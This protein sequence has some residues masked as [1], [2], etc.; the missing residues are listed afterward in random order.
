MFSWSNSKEG[1]V[2]EVSGMKNVL[3]NLLL[4]QREGI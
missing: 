4:P 1:E 2:K 3:E